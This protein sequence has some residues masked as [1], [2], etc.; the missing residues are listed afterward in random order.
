[1]IFFNVLSLC[2]FGALFF[3][4]DLFFRA[5]LRFLRLMVF[6]VPFPVSTANAQVKAVANPQAMGINGSIYPPE[7]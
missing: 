5:F 1:M 6:C 3:F 2:D 7:N 4:Q